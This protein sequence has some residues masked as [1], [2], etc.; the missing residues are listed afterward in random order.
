[1]TIS[2]KIK[3]LCK[4]KHIKQ[5]KMLEDLNINPNAIYIWNKRNTIPSALICYNI[6]KYLECRIED[7]LDLP[8]LE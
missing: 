5:Q 2:T 7:L 6:A 8:Y 4:E 3:Q 1:M